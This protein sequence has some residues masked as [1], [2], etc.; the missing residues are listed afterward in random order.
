MERGSRSAQGHQAAFRF[1]LTVVTGEAGKGLPIQYRSRRHRPQGRPLRQKVSVRC[2]WYAGGVCGLTY[3]VIMARLR[4][5]SPGRIFQNPFPI[6]GHT[7]RKY[8]SPIPSITYQTQP[9]NS[10]PPHGKIPIKDTSMS[11]T[12]RPQLEPNQSKP[13]LIMNGFFNKSHPRTHGRR[14][15]LPRTEVHRP[16]PRPASPTPNRSSWAS[17]STTQPA[18]RPAKPKASTPSKP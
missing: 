11:I 4:R 7:P 3:Q 5:S 17:R 16:R 1:S 13:R 10:P 12:D 18:S 2:K 9:Q 6:A 14:T 15:H 8:F